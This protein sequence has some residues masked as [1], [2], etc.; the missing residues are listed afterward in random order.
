MHVKIEFAIHTLEST[1]Y[2]LRHE[3]ALE[4]NS[5]YIAWKDKMEA[6]LEMMDSRNSLINK[7]LSLQHLLLKIWLN[8][9]SVWEREGRLSLRS[10]ISHFSSLHGKETPYPM[11]KALMYLFQNIS[12]HRKFALKDKLRKIKM[13]KGNSIMK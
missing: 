3:Y 6:V 4:G 12:D 2:G 5:N 7:F 13:E 1:I 8:G 10:L 9:E 11:W